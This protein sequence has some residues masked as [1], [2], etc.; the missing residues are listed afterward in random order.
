MVE[1]GG[2]VESYSVPD[3]TA[4]VI[5]KA[6]AAQVAAT[7]AVDSAVDEATDAVQDAVEEASR[8]VDI[9]VPNLDDT[10]KSAVSKI[11]TVTGLG[12]AEAAKLYDAGVAKA[13]ALLDRAATPQGREELAAATSLDSG[14]ILIQAKKIDLMRIKGVGVK[15]AALLLA[16]GVD[17]VPELATRNPK[18]LAAKM[19]ETNEEEGLVEDLPSEDQVGDWVAQAKE[20]PRMLYY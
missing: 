8:A 15:Y 2:Q 17:T 18:N 11:A 14:E 16:S 4:D 12:V 9:D 19:E 13:S 3:E 7:E 1:E 6:A 10:A 5:T 20:L